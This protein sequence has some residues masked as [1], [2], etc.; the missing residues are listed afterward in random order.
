MPLTK[1]PP[2]GTLREQTAVMVMRKGGTITGLVTDEAGKPI[3]GVQFY[4]A[5]LYWFDSQKPAATSDADGR[6]RL[7]NLTFAKSGMNDPP[8]STQ[9][10][11]RTKK[12]AVVLQA[13]G[14]TPQLIHVDS[15]G[16]PRPLEI[17]LKPGKH[18][19]GRVV[20]ADGKP[21]QGVDVSTSNWL[22][23]RERFD[24]RAKTGA[25]GKFR[26]SDV[27]LAGVL[28]DF[29]KKDYVSV[30]DLPMSPDDKNQAGQEGYV[31]TLTAPLR[32]GGTI[33]DAETNRP[34]AR[35]T[36]TKGVEYDDGRAGVGTL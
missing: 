30:N 25:N 8:E 33:V 21:L 19:F 32:I 34:P 22:G 15:S 13:P 10:A 29:H 3:A 27:P 26:L 23:Y 4:T 28:Y 11:R 1:M 36:V 16:T 6:F 31:V 2:I 14:Y 12:A 7:T 9:R 35:C 24:R 5:E 20:D 18:V 17:K